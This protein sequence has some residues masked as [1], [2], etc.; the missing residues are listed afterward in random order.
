[1]VKKLLVSSLLCAN[2]NKTL[3]F[4]KI[5]IHFMTKLYMIIGCILL[6]TLCNAQGDTVRL[7]RTAIENRKVI[8][9]RPPQAVYFQ[10]GGSAPLLSAN[11]D[12][13]FGKKVNGAGFAVGA[14]FFGG[15]G[16]SVFS[17][18][19]S[20]NYLFGRRSDFI[21]LAAGATYLTGSIDDLFDDSNNSGGGV[22]YHLNAG[23]RHQPVTGGFFFRGGVSPLFFG[24]VYITSYYI[25]FGYNF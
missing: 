11:Y 15:T 13:R 18:P 2:W 6:S 22:F 1:M 23:Y 9:D 5:R 12:R 20:L 3:S 14:G 17:V 25:G 24:D 7:K 10:L 21:E 8:T 16:F 19:A 4:I